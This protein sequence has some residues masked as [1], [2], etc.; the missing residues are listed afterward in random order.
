ML[1][2]LCYLKAPACI[3]VGQSAGVLPTVSRPKEIKKKKKNIL[4]KNI[5]ATAHY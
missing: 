3:R 2:A 1:M 5:F 4:I